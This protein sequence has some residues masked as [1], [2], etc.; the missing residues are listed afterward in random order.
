MKKRKYI[1]RRLYYS[2][3]CTKCGKPFKSFKRSRIKGGVCKR[4]TCRYGAPDNQV[5]MFVDEASPVGDRQATILM[6]G[7]KVMGVKIT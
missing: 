4:K 2:E 1:E 3:T 6:K 7:N 5:R